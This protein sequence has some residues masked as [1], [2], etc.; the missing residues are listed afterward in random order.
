MKRFTIG[1]CLLAGLSLTATAVERDQTLEL[2]IKGGIGLYQGEIDAQDIG[3]YGEISADYWATPHFSIGLRVSLAQLTAEDGPANF[4][5]DVIAISPRVRWVPFPNLAL[6]PYL[7]SGL[8]YFSFDP[9]DVNTENM[10]P[11]NAAGQY[12]T[13]RVGVPVGA[14]LS[15]DLGDRVSLGAEALYHFAWTDMLDDVSV[16][17]SNDGYFSVAVGLAIH[18][19][20][21][22]DTDGDGIPDKKDAAPLEREDFDGFQDEDGAPDPD[23]DNDGVPD[24]RD[25]APNDPEDFDGW[26]DAD[27]VPDPDNDGDGIPDLSDFAPNEAEDMDGWQDEDGAPDRDN[28]GDGILD[29]VDACPNEAETFNGFEDSDGCPDVKPEIAVEKGQSIVLA[30]ITFDSGKASLAGASSTE[31]NKVLRTLQSH[32]ALE[33]EI[34]GFTDSRGSKAFNTKLSQQRADEVKRWL[35]DR[36]IDAAR[37][38]TKGYGPASPVAD[39]GTAAGRAQNRRIEFKRVN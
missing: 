13:E 9:L 2:G 20:K 30:G 12:D 1:I 39:N 23:N 17:S 29:T 3:A 22:R 25:G 16:G 36:G 11:G 33:V 10:L 27:G 5:S 18:L 32:P 37:I 7:T 8:E 31:L 4:Q 24:V 6:M 26:Q 38:S 34:Q 19:G 28:D 35:T 14:G 15:I 21:A